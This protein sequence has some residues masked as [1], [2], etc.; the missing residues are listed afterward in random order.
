MVDTE[1]TNDAEA[2]KSRFE[3]ALR[4]ALEAVGLQAEGDVQLLCPVDTGLLR[5]SITH[6]VQG[7]KT[8]IESYKSNE[9][10]AST[11]ATR[12]AGTAGKP[13][14][15]VIEGQYTGEVSDGTG[16]LKVFIGTNVFYAPYVEFGTSK[17]D[18]HPF[19]KPAI[20]SNLSTYKDILKLYLASNM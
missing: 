9:V 10:H 1:V 6:A 3:A 18:P 5:N 14:K 11:D 15:E 2:V 8:S 4:I 12:R 19:M 17:T 7:A 16:K 20:Q 13:V